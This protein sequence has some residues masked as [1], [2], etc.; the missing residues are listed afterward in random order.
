MEQT[1]QGRRNS[2]QDDTRIG[3]PKTSVSGDN[4]KIT[5]EMVMSNRRITAED[6]AEEIPYCI[7]L[8]MLFYVTI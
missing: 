6:L 2:T 3:R 8:V 5:K 1:F 4:V 7:G